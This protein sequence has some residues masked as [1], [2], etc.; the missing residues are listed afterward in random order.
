MVLE[1][2]IERVT[3]YSSMSATATAQSKKQKAVD[4]GNKF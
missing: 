3:R 4:K 2:M 1:E